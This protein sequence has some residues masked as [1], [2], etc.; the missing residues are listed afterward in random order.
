[1][2]SED[3][4]QAA[5]PGWPTAGVFKLIEIQDKLENQIV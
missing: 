5:V 1:M 3:S 4:K 2:L